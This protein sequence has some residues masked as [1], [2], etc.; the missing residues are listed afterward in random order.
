MLLFCTCVLSFTLSF[1]LNVYL[2]S[3]CSLQNAL[4]FPS[5]INKII[6][7]LILCLYRGLS[8]FF[9]CRL[10]SSANESHRKW[11]RY[12][13]FSR[14]T[15][16]DPRTK[17]NDPWGNWIRASEPEITLISVETNRVQGVAHHSEAAVHARLHVAAAKR[18]HLTQLPGDLHGLVQQDTEVP[19]VSQAAGARHLLKQVWDTDAEVQGRQDEE[20]RRRSRAPC[21]RWI[22][23]ISFKWRRVMALKMY[24]SITWSDNSPLILIYRVK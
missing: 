1:A 12:L 21:G 24:N 8:D 23:R 6:L 18:G 2:C 10:F 22:T 15:R 5:G 4:E 11:K 16:Y 19:L 14:L 7:I 13:Y 9:F 3:I 17:V 20:G